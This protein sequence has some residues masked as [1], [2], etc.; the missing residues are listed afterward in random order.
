MSD[1]RNCI[2]HWFPKLQAAGVAV[3]ETTLI[4]CPRGLDQ[5]IYQPAGEQDTTLVT[6]YNALLEQIRA[7]VVARSGRAF[8]RTGYLSAKH[9]YR[10]TCNIDVDPES[11]TAA[12]LARPVCE[13]LDHSNNAWLPADVW[14]VRQ[15]IPLEARFTCFCDLP[16]ARERRYFIVGGG[17]QCHH[18]YWPAAALAEW[19]DSRQRAIDDFECNIPGPPPDWAADLAELNTESDEEVELLS[20]LARQVAAEFEGDE[21]W[22]LDFAKGQDGQWYA[23]DMALAAESFHWEGCP[24]A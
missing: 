1:E 22:S 13:L 24:H 21:G 3:P 5:L 15:F 11:V 4:E 10:N 19:F 18:P 17:V 2:S 16:I 9:S 20:G 7:A 14:A 8:L 12:D 6:A 23:I